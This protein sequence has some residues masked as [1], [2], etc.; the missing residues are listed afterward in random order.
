MFI[1]NT[2]STLGSAGS[3][4]ASP[5]SAKAQLTAAADNNSNFDSTNKNFVCVL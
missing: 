4:T 2:S 3:L 1:S 5:A